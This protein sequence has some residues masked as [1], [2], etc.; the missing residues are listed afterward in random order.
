M[1]NEVLD[2][3]TDQFDRKFMNCYQRQAIVFLARNHIPTQF[4]FGNAAIK[5]D[6]LFRQ[7]IQNKKHKYEFESGFFSHADMNLL[8]IQC[9][10]MAADSFDEIESEIEHQLSSDIRSGENFVMLP[11]DV[12]YLP[13]CPEFKNTHLLHM[14]TVTKTDGNSWSIVD[15]DESS[16]LCRYSYQRSY[17]KSFF[18]NSTYKNISYFDLREAF[19][20]EQALPTLKRVFSER[21]KAHEDSYFLLDHVEDILNDPYCSKELSLRTLHDSFSLFSGSRTG[22]ASFLGLIEPEKKAMNKSL[23]IAKLSFVIK[24]MIMKAQ[25]TGRLNTVGF[26]ER[27]QQ[28]KTSDSQMIDILRATNFDEYI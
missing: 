12:Y 11:G 24:S 2:Y 21:T 6:E 28:L 19:S 7:I 3:E 5:T 17:I 15:D 8:G 22:L 26:V 25:V 1:A 27:C 4:F 10:E 20:I 18:E 13:H 16:V 9:I 23:E 14:I